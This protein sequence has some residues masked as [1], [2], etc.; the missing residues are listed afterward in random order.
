[1]IS[2]TLAFTI[3][4]VA[5]ILGVIIARSFNSNNDNNYDLVEAK[6]NTITRLSRE[7]RSAKDTIEK[8]K[9]TFGIEERELSSVKYAKT[10]EMDS[11][12]DALTDRDNTIDLLRLRYKSL[13]STVM[14]LYTELGGEEYDTGINID[15]LVSSRHITEIPSTC[16]IIA[17]KENDLNARI[18][19]KI[20]SLKSRTKYLDPDKLIKITKDDLEIIMHEMMVKYQKDNDIVVKGMTLEVTNEGITHYI[21]PVLGYREVHIKGKTKI[22]SINL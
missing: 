2:P 19:M 1:M 10:H 3:C 12:K 16:S 22:T 20:K 9:H 6:N 15:R 14:V 8:Y 4:V 7:L 11:L 18:F 13:L 17:A 5:F 21:S